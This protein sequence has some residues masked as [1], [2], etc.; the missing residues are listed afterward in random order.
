MGNPKAKHNFGNPSSGKK[1]Q[2]LM[3][4]VGETEKAPTSC[5]LGC[6][7]PETNMETQKGP[8]EDSSPSKK[9]LYGF[10]C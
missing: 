2:L 6:T 7:L 1:M 8:Y 5:G 3:K 9:G 10:P 4:Y